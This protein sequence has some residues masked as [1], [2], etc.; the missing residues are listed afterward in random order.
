MSSI[1]LPKSLYL[2]LDGSLNR[3]S[4]GLLG[5]CYE[6]GLYVVRYCKVWKPTNKQ[7]IDYNEVKAEILK[8]QNS[9]LLNLLVVDPSGIWPLLDDL[10]KSGVTVKTIGQTRERYKTDALLLQVLRDRKLRYPQIPALSQH[11]AGSE[12][13]EDQNG[14]RI[15]KVSG[16]DNDLIICLSMAIYFAWRQNEKGSS[17]MKQ[18]PSNPFY[19]P[20]RPDEDGQ[21]RSD[22]AS[23]I[24]DP[25]SGLWQS[26]LQVNL[27]QN[28]R[29]RG[30]RYSTCRL[31]NRG[32]CRICNSFIDKSGYHRMNDESKNGFIRNIKSGVYD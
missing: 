18:F 29:A 15:T 9:G 20:L 31:R 22:D 27:G 2:G 5:V 3:N 10:K 23:R 6:A 4:T 12:I 1:T 13:K 14:A 30:H 24:F 7:P 21:Y 26:E 16:Q 25:N 8:L 28:V 19:D 11:L 17:Q 32:V